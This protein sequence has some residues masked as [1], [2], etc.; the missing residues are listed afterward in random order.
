MPFDNPQHGEVT[1]EL[2]LRQAALYLAQNDPRP[3]PP[4]LVVHDQDGN[5]IVSQGHDWAS[6]VGRALGHS[7]ISVLAW[8]RERSLTK[9]GRRARGWRYPRPSVAKLHMLL[10]VC[11]VPGLEPLEEWG[12]EAKRRGWNMAVLAETFDKSDVTVWRMVAKPSID[13]KYAMAT[14]AAGYP[15]P[16]IFREWAAGALD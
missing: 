14:L 8:V 1:L 9:E 7:Y 4:M 2:W 15:V 13:W 6:H 3:L 12:A 16:P 11:L 10:G 5:P